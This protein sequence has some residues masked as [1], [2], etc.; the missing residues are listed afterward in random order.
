MSVTCSG[1]RLVL[2]SKIMISICLLLAIMA[3]FSGCATIG[4]QNSRYINVNSD[5]IGA[6]IC[7]DNK[8]YGKTPATIQLPEYIYGGKTIVLKKKGFIERSIDIRTS[9]QFISLLDAFFWP[10]F[11]VDGITGS[12]VRIHDDSKDVF[13]TLQGEIND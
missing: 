4:G 3:V 11:I 9:F 1:R 2:F 5:P 12:L 7:I 13:I 8:I 6:D 10:G